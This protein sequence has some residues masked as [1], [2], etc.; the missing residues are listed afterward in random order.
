MRIRKRSRRLVSTSIFAGTL[1]GALVGGVLL[2]SGSQA[3][4]EELS[5]GR[6]FGTA[7]EIEV[8]LEPVLSI[9][10]STD[11]IDLVL[12]SQGVST[13]GTGTADINVSTNAATGYTLFITTNDASQNALQHDNVNIKSKINSLNQAYGE[14]DFPTNSW[15][16]S[17]DDGEAFSGIPVKGSETAVLKST[18]EMSS[19]SQTKLTI[20]AKVDDNIPSGTYRQTLLLTAV[21]NAGS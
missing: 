17:V 19:S 14:A 11:A 3:S 10:T 21:P 12:E 15:G 16:Y 20:G 4:A 9:S 5:G 18:N 8:V 13:F 6:V 7:S 1:I 2:P